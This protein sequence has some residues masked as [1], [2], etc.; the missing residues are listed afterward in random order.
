MSAAVERARVARV[1]TAARRHP[2][3][4]GKVGD[5]TLPFGPY[6]PAQL[7]VMAGGAMVLIKTFAWWS[8][9][10]PVPVVVWGLAVWA[11]RG[12][13]IGGRSPWAAAEGWLTLAALPQGGRIGARAARDR[14][15]TRLTGVFVIE[16]APPAAVGA[17]RHGARSSHG[18]GTG[19][20]SRPARPVTGLEGLLQ[21]AGTA[22]GVG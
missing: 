14:R 15:P 3:V 1:Y 22:G 17:A 5:W 21:R 16:A 10:G 12:A 4:L 20:P 18:G 8:W 7:V 13:K 9:L 2:W 11:V 6:T 19:R